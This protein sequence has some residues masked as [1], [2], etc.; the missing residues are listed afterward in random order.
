MENPTPLN[1]LWAWLVLFFITR[2]QYGLFSTMDQEKILA[3]MIAEQEVT[4]YELG[5]WA[6]ID[7]STYSR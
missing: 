6:G 3:R 7:S 5:D 2:V 4:K 1:K